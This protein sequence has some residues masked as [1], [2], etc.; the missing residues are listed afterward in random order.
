MIIKE[1]ND[2]GGGLVRSIGHD[3]HGTIIFKTTQDTDGI[4]E[5]NKAIRNAGGPKHKNMKHIA[6]V[7]KIFIEQWLKESGLRMGTREFLDYIK[8]KI[9][10][11]DYEAFKVTNGRY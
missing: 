11:P 1:V 5:S 2:M 9:N 8:K 7:P 10:D 4:V 3:A 6:R